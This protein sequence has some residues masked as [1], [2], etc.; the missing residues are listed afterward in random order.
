MPFPDFTNDSSQFTSDSS[1]DESMK[2]D[3]MM[4]ED[5][6]HYHQA[7][8]SARRLYFAL[9]AIGLTI[10]VVASIG[11]VMFLQRFGL[12]DVPSQ[13]ESVESQVESQ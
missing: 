12:T 1:Q 2:P 11:V 7:K 3:V 4:P 6:E 8:Q 10:G 13:A 9:I 5:V